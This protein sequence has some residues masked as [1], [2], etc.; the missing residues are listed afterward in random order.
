[1][2]RVVASGKSDASTAAEVVRCMQLGCRTSNTHCREIIPDRGRQR[3]IKSSALSTVPIRA[4][5]YRRFEYDEDGRWT[6]TTFFKHG[7][8]GSG[9]LVA[10]ANLETG[11]NADGIQ[12]PTGV[13]IKTHTLQEG[14]STAFDEKVI[15]IL[16]KVCSN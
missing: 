5:A 4:M 10:R 3:S 1:M 13:R 2:K 11:W 12:G 16:A 14:S 9:R 6:G 15:D 7:T 8:C